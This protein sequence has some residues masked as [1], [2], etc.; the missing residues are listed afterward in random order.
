[1]TTLTKLLSILFLGGFLSLAACGAPPTAGETGDVEVD[2]AQQGLDNRFTVPTC[3]ACC[4]KGGTW[5]SSHWL[6]CWPE[7]GGGK[8]CT[9]YPG[10]MKAK[11][12]VATG[13]AQ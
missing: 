13:F 5:D 8:T 12:G 9:N 4:Q 10:D 7:P 1:M 3:D 2:V 11:V 6:C